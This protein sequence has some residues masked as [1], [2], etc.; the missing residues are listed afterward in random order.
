MQTRR[1]TTIRT[2]A[3][4]LAHVDAEDIAAAEA[5]FS[6]VCADADAALALLCEYRLGWIDVMRRRDGDAQRRTSTVRLRAD[7][8]GWLYPS[9][10]ARRLNGYRLMF[11]GEYSAAIQP[12]REAYDGFS[13]AK[14]A[15][16]A[17]LTSAQL[18]DLFDVV[19]LLEEAWRW[20]L[21]ALKA[22]VVTPYGP[23]MYATALATAEMLAR[24][25][26]R[27]ASAVFIN[28]VS[29][30]HVRS[31]TS[32]QQA[33]LLISRARM[34]LATGNSNASYTNLEQ[35]D[36]LVRTAG[37][38]RLKRLLPDILAVRAAVE[39]LEAKPDRASR[40]L[41]EAMAAMGPERTAHRAAA[42]IARAGLFAHLP[43]RLDA[44]EDVNEAIALLRDRVQAPVGQPL[45]LDEAAPAFRAAAALVKANRAL[46][47][48]RGL[49][50]VEQLREVL[51]GVPQGA[52]HHDTSI[53]ATPPDRDRAVLFYLF[54]DDSL[55]AWVT[56][57]SGVAFAEIRYGRKRS[58]PTSKP[59]DR[60]G[61]SESR[62]RRSLATHALR[63]VRLGAS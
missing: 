59:V 27:E 34:L 17:G 1:A 56:S 8:R 54:T 7:E 48:P 13:A 12:Y 6:S 30:E 41:S 60:A 33:I 9:N 40:S 37:D 61:E 52:E 18:A 31:L 35:A 15:R 10:L 49:Q 16:H 20:R 2:V 43:G 55:L 39:Q 29:E 28:A 58:D 4:A 46:Q 51:D 5:A 53:A 24:R 25:Q 63:S 57:K 32:L 42:L 36:E 14:Y 23:L 50:L 62:P 19:G 22:A 45:R 38:F 47:G 26:E 11:R 21:V 3:S 44:S